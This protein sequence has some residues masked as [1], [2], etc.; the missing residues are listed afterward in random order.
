V[1]P[2]YTPDDIGALWTEAHRVRTWLQVEVAACEAMAAQ[3]LLPTEDVQA[4]RRAA[5]ACDTDKL[6]ERALEI[7]AVTKHDV[8]A[9]LT[10]FE[11]VAGPVARHVHYGMTSSDVLDTSLALRLVAAADIIERDL[12]A[13][14]AAVKVRAEEHRKTPMMGRSHGIHAEPITFGLVMAGWYAELTR[15][16]RR[17]R[18]ARDEIRCGKISGAVGTSAHLPL[19]VEAQALAALGL[20]PEPVATQV[21][22][23]DRHAQFFGTLATIAASVERF[24][25]EVRHLQR[26]EVRE[27]E[28][29]FT[30]GQ[31]GSSAMPHKR[32]PIL[33]ENL[34]G[35]ARLVRGWAQAAY[36]NVALWHERD[37]S[38]SSV[39]R[40]IAPD[41]TITVVFMLRRMTRVV[42]GLVVYPERMMENLQQMRGLV[43][44]QPVL[45]ELTRRGLQRQ[46]AY[47]IV[48]RAAMRVWDEGLDLRSALLAD[49]ELMSTLTPEALEPCFDLSRHLANVDP[50][51]DRALA[52]AP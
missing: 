25:V 24:S 39:E 36:E 41:A 49:A 45:L 35:L 22:A 10:A 48:Q 37:I 3:G 12:L 14:R 18:Q 16:V 28:E 40:V 42:E 13:L 26:T 21:V 8:I 33:T 2:R 32:N 47:V 17:L 51:I 31:K 6:A 43:F 52:E 23:R 1:I 46:E 5:D 19:A 15:N 4:I 38:H 30:K 29:P 44:S 7:E 11:E 27:A 34:T 20:T 9:F 50:L